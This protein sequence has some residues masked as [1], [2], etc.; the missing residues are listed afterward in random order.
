MSKTST[1]IREQHYVPQ[2]YLRKFVNSKNVVQVLDCTQKRIE[3]PRG[4]KGICRED[5][6]YGIHSGQPDDASQQ[7]ETGFQKLEAKLA[8][9]IGPVIQKIL[10]VEL[11][12][13]SEKWTVAQLMST[14]WLRG[15]TMRTL[16][17]GMSEQVMKSINSFHFGS[18]CAGHIFD[19]FDEATGRTTPREVR[20]EVKSII[21]EKRYLLTFSNLLHLMMFEKIDEFAELFRSQQ[22]TIYISNLPKKFITSDSPVVVT[23][24]G[25]KGF[26]QPTFIER[27]HY[28]PLT[29]DICIKASC[30]T[31]DSQNQL[32]ME[33][34]IRGQ[35]IQI[36]DLNMTIASRAYHYAYATERESLDDIL[37]EIKRQEEFFATPDGREVLKMLEN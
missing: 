33:P 12:L 23:I 7:I 14:L 1:V 16:I 11:M 6:F 8:T 9:D 35:E 24:P 25:R 34:V 28:F 18:Q 31:K 17:N 32:V 27:T 20:E 22:W 13:E 29:P 19:Q 37:A 5:F 30:S 36:L 26:Y 21:V 4:T 2:F 3:A 10:N 15:P